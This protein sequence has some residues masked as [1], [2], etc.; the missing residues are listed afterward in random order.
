MLT[1]NEK[2]DESLKRNV[3][4]QAPTSLDRIKIVEV[5]KLLF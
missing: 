2:L 3:S 4:L 1:L 5:P